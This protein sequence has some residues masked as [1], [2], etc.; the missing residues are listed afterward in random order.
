[1]SGK[2]SVECID[3]KPLCRN[4]L[5]GFAVIRVEQMRPIARDYRCR[6]ASTNGRCGGFLR[7][8]V[9]PYLHLRDDVLYFGELDLSGGQIEDNTRRVLEQII[10]GLL[11]WERLALTEQQADA[12]NLPRITKV[13][14]RFKNGG[15]VHE[16]IETEALR[17]TKFV[18]RTSSP[19]AAYCP[20]CHCIE[21]K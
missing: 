16:A 19:P 11:N 5:R 20:A 3:F 6:I 18:R 15:G 1:M 9:A 4:T 2:L 21:R 10:G 13:D 17:L 7:A 8:D 14:R 12:Y